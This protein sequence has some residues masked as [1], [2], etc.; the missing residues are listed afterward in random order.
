[1][2]ESETT[3][4]SIDAERRRLRQ[5]ANDNGLNETELAV[6]LSALRLGTFLLAQDHPADQV[7][8]IV[9]AVAG[10]R[11]H[12]HHSR[13]VMEAIGRRMAGRDF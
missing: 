9:G 2:S 11:L 13:S 5:L 12:Q 6:A 10:N 7:A 1:M 4:A 8:A 3:I